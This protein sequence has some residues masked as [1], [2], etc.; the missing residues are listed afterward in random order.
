V[1]DRTC[2]DGAMEGGVTTPQ[3]CSFLFYEI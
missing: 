2:E 3:A 1:L